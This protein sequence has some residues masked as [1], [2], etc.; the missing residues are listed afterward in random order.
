MSHILSS[1]MVFAHAEDRRIVHVDEVPNGGKCGCLCPACKSPLIAKNGGDE[2]AH[3][4]A[5]DGRVEN[6]YCSETALHFA[7]KQIVSDN[8]KVRLPS[9]TLLSS[10]GGTIVDFSEMYIEHKLSTNTDDHSHIVADCFGVTG[11]QSIIMEIAVH[12]EVDQNK[13]MKI[14]SLGIPAIEISLR[15]FSNISWDWESLTNEVL[16]SAQ[17]RKWL[18]QP[19]ADSECEAMA[20]GIVSPVVKTD[21]SE[22][23]FD[24]GGRW[25][26]VKKLPYGNI[27]VFH[28]RNDYLRNI[29]QPLCQNRGYWNPK[30]NCWV[31][32]DRFKD[33]ILN[34][35]SQAGRILPN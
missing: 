34:S 33:D 12:H 2:R 10:E 20:E 35:L 29:V 21:Q 14:E 22:W 18:W 19:I 17:R 30:F 4:F 26:W 13:L 31:I 1:T 9:P 25:V 24:I 7:A 6:Q 8:K 5:H 27:K 23:I 3:H 11:N 28:R 16:Y 15:D 32:F